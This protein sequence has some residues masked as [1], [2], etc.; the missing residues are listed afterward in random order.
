MKL[1]DKLLKWDQLR[2][3]LKAAEEAGE[4][5]A[6]ENAVLRVENALLMLTINQMR[7][8]AEK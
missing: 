1:L 2:T 4:E 8:T 3:R 7:K 5:L 6:N